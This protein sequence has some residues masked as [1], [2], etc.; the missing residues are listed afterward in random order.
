MYITSV[1]KNPDFGAELS[2]LANFINFSVTIE[3]FEAQI[4]SILMIELETEVE[5]KQRVYRKQAMDWLTDLKNI[6]DKILYELT[7][8]QYDDDLIARDIL[9]EKLLD[10]KI[11][12]KK[13]G[14]GLIEIQNSMEELLE[15]SKMYKGI[16]MRAAR[17]F[18]ISA[19]LIKLNTMYLFTHEWFFSFFNKLLYNY[20]ATLALDESINKPMRISEL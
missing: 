3:A 2:L 1:S 19:D 15:V 11:I 7:Q 4:L 20:S 18:F 16:S 17:Y 6:E 9:I 14:K 13:I 5:A 12:S 8:P 10:S